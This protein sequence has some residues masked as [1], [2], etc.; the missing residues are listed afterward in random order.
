MRVS[1]VFCVATLVLF[2]CSMVMA[3]PMERQL[4]PDSKVVAVESAVPQV[5]FSGGGAG[6]VATGVATNY[7]YKND[8]FSGFGVF[9][10]YYP[11]TGPFFPGTLM[12]DEAILGNGF[13]P[14]KHSLTGMEVTIFRSSADPTN[15][16]TLA[17]YHVELWDGDPFGAVETPNSGVIA[18]CTFTGV[19]GPG[20]FTLGCDFGSKVMVDDAMVWVVIYGED[21]CRTGWIIS[22]KLPEVGDIFMDVNDLAMAQSDYDGQFTGLGH[23]CN[24]AVKPFDEPCDLISDPC[25]GDT[26]AR[27]F[28][29]DQDAESAWIFYFGGP[30]DGGINDFCASFSASIFSQTDF[31]VE[32]Q[33]R[34]T[35]GAE[36]GA[37]TKNGIVLE[38]GGAH[39]WMDIVYKAWS[40]MAQPQADTLVKTWQAKLDPSGYYSGMAGTLTPWNPP[41]TAAADCAA[42]QLDGACNDPAYPPGGC[43]PGFQNFDLDP[44]CLAAGGTVAGNGCLKMDLPAV[45][46]AT[47]AFV[48]GSTKIFGPEATDD[49]LPHYGGTLVLE[50]S[51]EAKGIFTVGWDVS[52]TWMKN[53]SEA[54]P[55]IGHVPGTIEVAT[56]QCCDLNVPYPFICVGDTFTA[57]ECEA[58]GA[59]FLFDNEK[60]CADPCGC[61]EDIHCDDGDACTDD[62][63][64]P[65]GT[66]GHS[67]TDCDDGL[68]CTV[69]LCNSDAVVTW[70]ADGCYY[71]DL[72][73]DD[74]TNCTIDSCVE[75][76]GCVNAKIDCNDD[77]VCSVDWCDE[78][79]GTCVNVNLDVPLPHQFVCPS[80]DLQIDCQGTVDQ[81]TGEMVATTC[82][83]GLCRCSVCDPKLPCSDPL[84]CRAN[85]LFDVWPSS[86]FPDAN[87]ACFAKGEKMIVDVVKTPGG[88][89]VPA[90]IPITAAQF[91]V[92]YDPDCLDFNSITPGEF[93]PFEI[94]Q[95]VDEVAGTIFYAVGVDPFAKFDGVGG[96]AVFAQLSFTKKSGCTNCNLTFG[97]VNPE[98]TFM[99]DADGQPV[100]ADTAP[101]NEVHEND[102]LSLKVPD[103]LKANVD[104]D[105]VTADVEWAAPWTSSSCEAEGCNPQ[106]DKCY[107]PN[108]TCW[109]Y[110]PNGNPLPTDVVMGGG[111]LPIGVSTFG[112]VA[113]SN[114]CGDS[115]D[116]GWTVTVNEQ[117]TLD[118]EVQLEPVILNDNVTRCITFELYEDCVAPPLILDVELK[119]GGKWD[120][121]GHFTDSFKIPTSGQWVCI[122]AMD[123]LHSLRSVSDLVCADGV[124]SAV[125]KGDP[126][127][128]GGNWLTQGN[129]DGWKK[130][131]PNASIDV[132]D[133]LDFGQFIAN[134]QSIVPKGTDCTMVHGEFG[135]A[136]INGDGV[137]DGLD[138]AFI[139]RN[140]LEGSKGACCPDGVAD[141]N[142][143]RSEVSTSDLRAWGMRDLV[144]ADLNGDGL[145]NVDDMAA[146]MAGDR[147]EGKTA[148]GRV[149]TLRGSK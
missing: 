5:I 77:I 131:N 68:A 119:F 41:C 9:L 84:A 65:D 48:Y 105:T 52:N 126:D 99:S 28:C 11:S 137:V 124:Y 121:V 10:N 83:D 135:N 132:I 43:S 44:V 114:I 69:D 6:G 25:T 79:T 33:P 59:G 12:A 14:A 127:Y 90:A 144:T 29:T 109:G 24:K 92:L 85:L 49:G 71:E 125:F 73:C 106:Q 58:F 89:P 55:M 91:V 134:Y 123:Q 129:L 50:V 101:S 128:F 34:K 13:D 111:T 86:K 103:D 35:D 21:T 8:Y 146:F 94:M 30:C 38:K 26:G 136:D 56:G 54:I 46:T 139:M 97:G 120:H 42:L 112:C 40:S 110:D 32:W 108:L 107:D 64:N 138:F 72:D 27:G 98:D 3:A 87:P 147:P 23:C 100:C 115:L 18:S 66:C 7:V 140:F 75:P 16:L 88:F 63:C 95:R 143:G 148:P 145:V 70:P 67:A 45:S 47:L 81:Y 104:C 22:S 37:M 113:T 74:Q 122:T 20:F 62:V 116:S 133:I 36:K 130:W 78:A 117:T 82:V 57:N 1:K 61:S 31:T 51:A 80:G 4:L 2:A 53:A 93:Y 76:G 141:V 102:K 118:V 17:T 15:G 60:T 149:N 39:V 142:S 19:P 96:A